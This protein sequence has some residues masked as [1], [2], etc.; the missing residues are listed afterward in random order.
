MV[1][2]LTVDGLQTASGETQ[3]LNIRFPIFNDRDE[4]THTGSVGID[5]RPDHLLFGQVIL[6]LSY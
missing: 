4:L 2:H 5:L 6:S 1:S 3:R